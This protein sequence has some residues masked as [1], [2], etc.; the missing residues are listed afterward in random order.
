MEDLKI[1][2][3]EEFKTIIENNNLELINNIAFAHGCAN[4]QGVLLHF[5]AFGNYPIAYKV[6][7]E[8]IKDAKYIR[9]KKQKDLV[10]KLSNE[11]TLVFIAMGGSF[12]PS[13]KDLI[14][15]HRIR[16]RFINNEGIMCFIEVVAYHNDKSFMRCDHSI[17]NYAEN[18]NSLRERDATEKNNY[19]DLERNSKQKYSYTNLLKLVN[20]EFN[21]SF[22]KLI[23]EEH[24]L[25]CDIFASI[26]NNKEVC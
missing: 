1:L 16:A 15:N 26:S 7:Q 21:C 18:W 24:L 25:S 14:D 4:S 13:N 22:D 23:V 6:T 20:K 10:K 9:L 5:K 11:N 8:Q 2:T 19:K 3:Q 12:E 17:F